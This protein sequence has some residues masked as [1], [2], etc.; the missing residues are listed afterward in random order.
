VL[1]FVLAACALLAASPA[2]RSVSSV[3]VPSGALAG[4]TDQGPAPAGN[5][6]RLAIEL[7]PRGDLDALAAR[8]ADPASP[9]HRA[10]LDSAAFDQRFGR[11]A[12]GRALG[13]L[14][15]HSGIANVWVARNGLVVSAIV[16]V[17]EAQQLF[18]ARWDRFGNGKRSAFAPTGPLTI[19]AANVRDVRG[20]I[21]ATTPRLDDVRA[22]YTGFRG[23]WYLPSRFRTMYDAIPGGGASRRI[24]LVEDASDAV[25]MGDVKTFANSEGAPPGVDP[26]R[27]LEDRSAF[28]TA[29]QDCGRDDR[30]QETAID[31]GAALTLAPL[32]Q[33]DVA[34]D[35]VCSFGNDGTGALARALEHDPSAI[36]FP[37]SVGPAR[38]SGVAATYGLTPLPYLEAIV[39]G[40]PIVVAAGDEG[41]YGYREAGIEEPAISWPCVLPVVICAGGTQ[42]GERDTIIDEA[43]WNDGAFATGGGISSEPRPSWQDA[44]SEFEFSPQFV[45]NRMVPDVS[46][47]AGGHLRIFW[48]GY[49]MGGVGGTSESAAIVAAQL[50][51]INGAVPAGHALLTAGDLYRLAK[52]HPEAFRQVTGENDR[53][54]Y[55]NTLRPRATPLPKDYRGIVP[56]PQPEVY[57]CKPAQP[58]GCLVKRGYNAVTGIGS[59]KEKAAVEALRAP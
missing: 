33:I 40:I 4:L 7:Q 56:T 21:A 46:A 52:A 22:P 32:A 59:L 54:Y 43:P 55:D 47:D 8:I 20:A 27:V 45:K 17:D 1:C 38:A 28:K 57:G 37:F 44:P 16:Q 50:V 41:A 14:L 3:T 36:V 31:V 53:R 2:P 19:P 26:A 9:D 23:D 11:V 5:L 49:A 24:V 15:S 30:G 42:L 12:D 34:Y 10:T 6:L 35:D 48:H 51:A 18:G 58:Q 25:D 13:E 39:R 29:S